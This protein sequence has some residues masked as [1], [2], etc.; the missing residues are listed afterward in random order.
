MK[1]KT[2]LVTGAS[3]GIGFE[4]CQV[5]ASKGY[6]IVL[7][8]RNIEK[9]EHAAERLRASFNIETHIISCDLA[10]PFAAQSLL[11]EVK[12]LGLNIDV[13]INNAG[14]LFNGLFADIELSNQEKL[15]QC[16]IVALTAL[17]HLFMG[18]MTRRGSG[19]ILNVASTAAWTAIPRQNVYAASKA[20]V[21]SFSHALSAELRASHSKVTVTVVCPSY[22]DTKMLDNPEQGAGINVPKFMKLSPAYVAEQGVKACLAGKPTS[23]PGW[24][25]LIGMLM[26]QVMPKMWLAKVVGRLYTRAGE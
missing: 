14:V 6:D 7:V 10:E 17:T 16:N 19:R 1:S 4:L 13:L 23:I 3:D 12:G 2:S 11:K 8:A 20:Y 24:S 21:L 22:T 25:N 9:L 26:L 15:L 18:E 5:M